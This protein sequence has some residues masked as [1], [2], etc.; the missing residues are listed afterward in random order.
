MK[1]RPPVPSVGADPG[2]AHD[3]KATL[4]N[5]DPVATLAGIRAAAGSWRGLD[6][7]ALKADLHRAREEGTRP[8][9]RPY[10]IW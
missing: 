5:F 3:D 8:S 9:E 6:T 2:S 1:Q 7:E 4:P 10:P